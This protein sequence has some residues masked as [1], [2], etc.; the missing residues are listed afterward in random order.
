MARREEILQ[1]LRSMLP[2]DALRAEDGFRAGIT[3]TVHAPLA[4]LREVAEAFDASGFYMESMTAV[5]F[6]DATDLVYHFNCYEPKSRIVVHVP[7]AGGDNAATLSD[8]FPAADWLE[9]EVREFFGI[10]FLG[11]KDP[12]NLLL[13]EDA[14]FHP[15]KKTYGSV[16]ANRKR[17]EIYG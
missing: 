13:P 12:R 11:H 5:D 16:H 14:D 7:C 1:K 3:C 10:Q 4:K 17:E 8:I 15:L 9:R 2:E 6:Q